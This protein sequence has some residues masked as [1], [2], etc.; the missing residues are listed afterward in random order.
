MEKQLLCMLFLVGEQFF[1]V[2]IIFYVYIY[3]VYEG[4]FD[5]M[6]YLVICVWIK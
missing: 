2:D 1:I 4:G 3:V 6:V 5:L